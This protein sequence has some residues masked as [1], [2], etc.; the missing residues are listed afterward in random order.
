MDIDIYFKIRGK[1]EGA[2]FSCNKRQL[3]HRHVEEYL[4]F[5]IQS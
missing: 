4:Q 2:K 1:L 5:K 3:L